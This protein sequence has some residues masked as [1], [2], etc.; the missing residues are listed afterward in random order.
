MTRLAGIIGHPLGHSVSPPMHQAAF[1]ALGMNVRYR[2]WNT[3]PIML[4]YRIDAMRRERC[5][6]ANVTVPH[7]IVA[8]EYVDEAEP[9]ARSI[10]AVNTIVNNEGQLT[11]HNTDAHGFVT[12]LKHEI[13]TT[14]A[15]VNALVLGAGGA[16]RA[17]VFGLAG[18]GAGSIAIANR[19]ASKAAAL[20]SD[21]GPSANARVVELGSEDFEHAAAA[22][23]LIVNCTSVGMAGGSSPGCTPISRELLRKGTLV[24]DMVYNPAV[25]PLLAAAA[26]A[27]AVGIGGLAMLVHQGA[28]AFELWTGQPAPLDAMFDAARTA[29]AELDEHD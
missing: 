8:F 26:D 12:S 22:A 20:A 18:E 21:A 23:D 15:G 13:G 9:L 3:P 6:G 7:K 5:L 14:L 16:A 24:F 4:P 29:M 25:T 28:S 27:G 2:R 19:T 1:D 17:A 10:G 11:G